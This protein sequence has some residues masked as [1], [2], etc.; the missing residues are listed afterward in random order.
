M[1]DLIQKLRQ[2][3]ATEPAS[4]FVDFVRPSLSQTFWRVETEELFRGSAANFLKNMIS[5]RFKIPQE[6]ICDAWLYLPRVAGGLGLRNFYLEVFL[7]SSSLEDDV[8][9]PNKTVENYLV[10]QLGVWT[11]AKADFERRARSG[12]R[13][14]DYLEPHGG[15]GDDGG[16][17]A[18]G[19]VSI[20]HYFTR[21]QLFRYKNEPFFS[22]NE[23][24]RNLPYTCQGLT[25]I[26]MRL[27]W[28]L[29]APRH[30]LTRF[31]PVLTNWINWEILSEPEKW[32]CNLYL[33]EVLHKF[34]SFPIVD[35]LLVFQGMATHAIQ[36]VERW[37]ESPDSLASGG[38]AI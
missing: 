18:D 30:L 1:D 22:R 4:R 5:D 19:R 2:N 29:K 8:E 16:R 35:N 14:E 12:H 37:S 15:A 33:K 31:D 24:F 13:E 3:N 25:D 17:R 10:E 21:E 34:G 9:D 26:L 27:Q 7:I 11:R 23:F 28:D 36:T 20:E 38:P 32:L 6:E